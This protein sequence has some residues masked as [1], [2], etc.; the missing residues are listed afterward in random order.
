M[1]RS[2]FL[3]S[4]LAFAAIVGLAACGDA[5]GVPSTAQVQ[6]L[7]TDAPSDY[8]SAAMVDIGRV[9]LLP[10][11]EGD[12]IVL[13]E[14][15]TDGPVDLLDL[16]GLTT[17]VLADTE[18]PAGFYKELRLIVQSASVVLAEPY[19]FRDGAVTAE[20][21]VP[22]GASSGIKLKLRGEHVSE[23]D[24]P[25]E[26]EG[27]SEEFEGIEIAGGQTIL[28]VDFDVNQSF[29]LQG[30]PETSAG[31][32]GMSFKPTLRVVV[33]DLAGS[34]SGTVST[35]LADTPVEGLVVKAET[36]DPGDVEEFETQTATALTDASGGYTI[37]FVAPGEYSVTVETPD[38]L[39]TT[40]ASVTVVVEEAGDVVGVDFEVVAG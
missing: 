18:I 40:P 26:V 14:D 24:D 11:D 8:V 36:V 9:E 32:N 23:G 35:A 13:S 10:A 19:T 12:R 20:L 30:N 7:L 29:R 37:Y 17:E 25:A 3:R 33:S 28:V 22:S 2:L 27:E 38:G 15:G 5:L 39:V 6:V 34:I 21:R 4:T 31:I 1:S 16:Q